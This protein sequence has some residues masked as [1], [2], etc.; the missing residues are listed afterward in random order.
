MPNPSIIL[1]P[2]EKI[3][4]LAV[5]KVASGSIMAAILWAQGRV[6]MGQEP[7]KVH[8]P[9]WFQYTSKEYVRD[10]C[11]D[12]FKFT[13]VRNP[14]D[15]AVSCWAE[16]VRDQRFLPLI[17]K[18]GLS[19]ETSFKEFVKKIASILDKDAEQHVQ[20]Q[21]LLLVLG[22]RLLPSFVGNF[23]RIEVHWE[24]IKDRVKDRLS[25]P[26]LPRYTASGH[27]LYQNYYDDETVELIAQRYQ[28]DIERFGY[29]F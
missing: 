22:G 4:F 26:E 20:S 2:E 17:R 24:I 7:K 14:W 19:K 25:L 3:V 23:E 28:E 10:I 9:H 8:S 6:P 27:L 29:K 16:K 18:Y 13:F 5:P 21:S 12:F 1:L 11:S 15:R